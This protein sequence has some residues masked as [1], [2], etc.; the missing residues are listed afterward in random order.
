M[1]AEIF[2]TVLT[3]LRDNDEYVQK[4]VATLIREIAKH[5]PEVDI[6]TTQSFATFQMCTCNVVISTNSQRWWSGSNC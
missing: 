2:P 6:Q 4:N 5:T 1:E 3:S